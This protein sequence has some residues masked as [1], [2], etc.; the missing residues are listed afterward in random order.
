[1]PNTVLQLCD[2]GLASFAPSRSNIL[3]G[4]RMTI[5]LTRFASFRDIILHFGEDHNI[6]VPAQSIA[7]EFDSDGFP[8]LSKIVITSPPLLFVRRPDFT[9]QIS[10]THNGQG[11]PGSTQVPGCFC[12]LQLPATILVATDSA[13]SVS[14]FC[15]PIRRPQFGHS[16]FC[17]PTVDVCSRPNNDRTG[18][19]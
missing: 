3:G 9:V 1:M 4:S 7:N 15:V 5:F 11:R 19:Y 16:G 13:I 17:K 6:N 12:L 10:M 2:T 18:S 8:V 14:V